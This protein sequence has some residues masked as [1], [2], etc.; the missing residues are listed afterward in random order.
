MTDSHSGV[1]FG[2]LV[3]RDTEPPSA[4]LVYSMNHEEKH[5]RGSDV[6]C[7]HCAAGREVREAHEIPEPVL[8]GMAEDAPVFVVPTEPVDCSMC[9][10]TYGE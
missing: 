2:E 10:V 5:S 4:V 6:V 3:D 8:W 7:I 1:P 9:G